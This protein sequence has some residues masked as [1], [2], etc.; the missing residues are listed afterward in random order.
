MILSFENGS[1][2]ASFSFIETFETSIA[3]LHQINVKN[4]LTVGFE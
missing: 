2:Q 1:C 4:D 3:I